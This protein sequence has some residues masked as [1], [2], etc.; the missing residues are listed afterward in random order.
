MWIDSQNKI[1]ITTLTNKI[2]HFGNSMAYASK[3]I[4][5]TIKKYLESSKFDLFGT[6][7][8]IKFFYKE[9]A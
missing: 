9:H 8:Y 5:H 6:C 4:Y 7:Q 1:F 2:C 3:R